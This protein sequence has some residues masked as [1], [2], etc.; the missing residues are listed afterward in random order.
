MNPNY[1]FVQ[2]STSENQEAK[3]EFEDLKK[4]PVIQSIN[5]FKQ[6][7]VSVYVVDPLM[8]G[9]PAYS[10]IKE[11]YPNGKFISYEYQSDYYYDVRME[12]NE[13]GWNLHLVVEKFEKTFKKRDLDNLFED[14]RGELE[15]YAALLHK[16]EVGIITINYSD[17]NQSCVICDLYVYEEFKRQGIGREL[18]HFACDRAKELNC[19]MI[20][21]ETQ[22]SNHPAIQ[23][24]VACGF[25]LVGINVMSYSNHDIEKKEVRIELAQCLD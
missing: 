20:T 8:E 14:D 23:F 18:I 19:R 17:W 10:R 7:H 12:S 1:L 3:M 6:D 13:R 24:Y 4:N 16:Q 9:G 22:T 15:Y 2:F 11:D 25:T 21:L 5:A